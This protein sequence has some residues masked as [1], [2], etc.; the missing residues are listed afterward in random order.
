MLYVNYSI[1]QLQG[2]FKS[3]CRMVRNSVRKQTDKQPQYIQPDR[4]D[5]LPDM[6][7]TY[8]VFIG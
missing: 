1:D 8:L 7:N 3:R 2:S 4:N 5:A 6:W